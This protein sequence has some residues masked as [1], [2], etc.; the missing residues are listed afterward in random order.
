MFV[1]FFKVRKRRTQFSADFGALSRIE[2]E[3]EYTFIHF[4]S[5]VKFVAEPRR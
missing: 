1:H 5:Q 4:E 3:Y 2:P